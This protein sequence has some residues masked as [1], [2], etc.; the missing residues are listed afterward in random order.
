MDKRLLKFGEERRLGLV[1]QPMKLE[2]AQAFT[3]EHHRHTPPLKRHMF[4]IAAY[5]VTETGILIRR[6]L[7][8]IATVDRC[9]SAWS[10]YSDRLEIRRLC[11]TPDAPK[12]TCSFLLGK[13]KQA[14]FGMGYKVL[15]TYTQPHE[16]GA[17]LK[18]AGFCIDKR[19]KIIRYTD[20]S[21][22]GGLV[23]WIAEEGCQPDAKDREFTDR[24]LNDLQSF[25]N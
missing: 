21:I 22:E 24:I 3:E 4:T 20:G 18:G 14:V 19:A 7:R 16:S 5:E 2:H 12:N 10:S 6:E 1:H 9:S 8:G 17:S 13:C 11:V 15:V 23:R 25:V